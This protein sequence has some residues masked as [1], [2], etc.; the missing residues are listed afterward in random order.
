[1]YAAAPAVALEHPGHVLENIA[2]HDG[3]MFALVDFVLINGLAQ[4]DAVRQQ[5][6]EAVFGE[7]VTAAFMPLAGGPVLGGPAAV[8][9]FLG[10]FEERFVF[11]VEFEDAADPLG[12]VLVDHQLALDDV[13]T[14]HRH[15]AGP[16]TLAAG[17]GNLVAGS[18]GDNLAFELGEREQ[19][20]E[21][22]AAH[23][24]AGVEL[25]GDGDEGHFPAF[26]HVHD[27][28][29]VHQAAAE[30]V[31]LVDDDTVD[32]TGLHVGHQAL[33]GRALHVGPGESAVIVTVRQADPALVF[34]AGDIGLARLT[35][36]VE[37]VEFLLQAFL[38]ALAGVNRAA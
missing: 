28:G 17:G 24:R 37:R 27:L 22:Q 3:L 16:F 12:L 25:L 1:M 35:L 10:R 36:G 6:E 5:L 21:H 34:L 8:G 11:E 23:R 9:Q 18:L 13:I 14:Q 33:D 32:P 31:H 20:V 7:L 19:H 29:E 15:A 26:Q 4:V 2:C 38:S 30:P